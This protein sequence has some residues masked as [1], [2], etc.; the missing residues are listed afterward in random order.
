[1]VALATGAIVVF[2][3]FILLTG[4]VEFAGFI[5]LAG[6]FAAGAFAA[7]AFAAGAFAAGA[8]AAGALFAGLALFVVPV[9]PQAIPKAHITRTAESAIT[10]IILFTNSYL[11]QRLNYL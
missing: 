5:L 7:G 6:A 11:S 2:A 10:F 8:F 9:S 3:G 4:A 1:L